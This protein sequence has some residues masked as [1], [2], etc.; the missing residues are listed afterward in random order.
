MR[1]VFGNLAESLRREPRH[2][3]V[4]LLWPKHGDVVAAVPGM[5]LIERSQWLEVFEA[6]AHGP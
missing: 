5:R 3:V 1:R 6:H 4:L 2:A